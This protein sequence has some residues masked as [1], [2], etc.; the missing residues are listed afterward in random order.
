MFLASRALSDEWQKR[1]H[2]KRLITLLILLTAA[3]LTSHI[4]ALYHAYKDTEFYVDR[5]LLCA[6][7]D[8]VEDQ[9]LILGIAAEKEH[10]YPMILSEPRRYE[11]RGSSACETATIARHV[12][13]RAQAILSTIHDSIRPIFP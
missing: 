13:D 12:I 4:P 3:F 9:R 11:G 6:W 7:T 1:A 2:M 5:D 10:E 8:P